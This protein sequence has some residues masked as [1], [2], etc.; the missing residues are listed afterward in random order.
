MPRHSVL[1]R[2]PA[3]LVTLAA[4]VAAACH[5]MPNE[6]GARFAEDGL[7][8][9]MSGGEGG[10]TNACF[11]C[12]GLAGHGDG[13]SVPRLAG[14][15]AGYLQKQMEDYATNVRHDPVMGPIAGWLSHDD[16]RAVAAYYAGLPPPQSADAFAPPPA[17]YL[18]GAPERGVE[19]CAVC[20]GRNGEGV[21]PANPA[22][23]G[24][25]AA[26]TIE[27]IRRWRRG[28]RRND[29]RRVMADAV[30]GL[31]D[32]EARAIAAWLETSPALPAPAS[33]A[34]SAS[35]AATAAARP[36]ASHGA[37]RPGR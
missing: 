9:A 10:A 3:L 29:P 34:A 28:E 7:T 32:D 35:A 22:L 12:H 11:V 24:Q 4:A 1:V 8:L 13:V 17:I 23:T 36:E 31:T 15:D 27:Q 14:L 16:R 30:A 2:T 20:H 5:P 21:G 6:T 33:D 19:A 18:T 26:Y 37:R 25:P